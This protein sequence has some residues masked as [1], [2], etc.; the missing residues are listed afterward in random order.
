MLDWATSR[1]WWSGILGFQSPKSRS[2]AR[3][4][5]LSGTQRGF[6]GWRAFSVDLV[7]SIANDVADDQGVGFLF[8]GE[9]FAGLVDPGD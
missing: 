4:A 3:S 8:L 9:A 1:R 5:S 7:D 2:Q 6:A